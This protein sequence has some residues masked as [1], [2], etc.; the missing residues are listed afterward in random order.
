[1]YMKANTLFAKRRIEAESLPIGKPR[2]RI[3]ILEEA[4][5]AASG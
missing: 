4:L 2:T 3:S 1:M 5:T